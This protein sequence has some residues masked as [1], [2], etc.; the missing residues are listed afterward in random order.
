MSMQ[1]EAIEMLVAVGSTNPVKIEAVRRAFSSIWEVE[2]RG[3]K[4]DSGVSAEPIGQE[5]IVGAMNRA[6]RAMAALN[7]DFGV[8][9]EGGVFHLGGRYCCAGFVWVER[10][11][12]AYGTGTSGWFECPRKFTASLLTGVELGDLMAEISGKAEIK[13]EEGAIGYFTRGVVSRTDLYTH[14]VLMALAKFIAGDRW[15][16]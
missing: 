2:V 13:R 14:G 7:A 10:K 16:G 3:V 1:S 11:D 15:P 9:I 8:G 12:G 4:V 6:R 5:A